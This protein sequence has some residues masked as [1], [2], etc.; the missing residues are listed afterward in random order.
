MCEGIRAIGMQFCS[1][2]LLFWLAV[3]FI[4]I[5]PEQT[6]K[7]SQFVDSSSITTYKW[8][9]GKKSQCTPDDD[10]TGDTRRYTSSSCTR[11]C[12]PP[13]VRKWLLLSMYRVCRICNTHTIAMTWWKVINASV[14]I[15]RLRNYSRWKVLF[16]LLGKHLQFF[17][18]PSH[19]SFCLLSDCSPL[20]FAPFQ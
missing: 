1:L 12:L 9:I 3:G 2:L 17:S 10:R 8:Q 19:F 15:V 13:C 20:F 7:M 16:G 6:V 5:H 11:L 14:I 18:L 4:Q